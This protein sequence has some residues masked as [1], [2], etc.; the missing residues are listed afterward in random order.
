[1][2]PK[3]ITRV[4]LFTAGN[5]ESRLR[6]PFEDLAQSMKN[7]LGKD[8]IR[9]A[10]VNNA[11]PSLAEIAE[12]AGNDGVTRL[13]ILPLF[14]APG[15]PLE[16]EIP[17]QVAVIRGQVPQIK[18][19]LLPSVGDHERMRMLLHALAREAANF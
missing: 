4:V 2:S 5:P 1:M 18:I 6:K 9:L 10:Y 16:R 11:T 8:R 12:E 17:E 13:R 15:G 14:L 19:E 7:E 3:E